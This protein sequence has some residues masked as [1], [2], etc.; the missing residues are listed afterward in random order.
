MYELANEKKCNYL[1]IESTGISELLPVATT[2]DFRD[3]EGQSL[4]DVIFEKLEDPFP[5]WFKK[6]G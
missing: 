4:S 5:Q 2:F 6:A 1:L 3:E